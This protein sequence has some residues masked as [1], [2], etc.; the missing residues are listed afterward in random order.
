MK[1]NLSFKKLLPHLLV[2]VGFMV[3]SVAYV[4]P[5]LKGK[6][7]KQ[8]DVVQGAG[9]SHEAME[10]MKSTGEWT[11]W[12]N[13]LFGG[14]PTFMVQGGYA[15]GILVY[16]SQ[17]TNSFLWTYGGMIFFYLLGVYL[18]LMALE[19]GIW[20]SVL[21]AVAYAFFSYNIIIIE[22]G[23]N[24]K[25]IAL[26]F[27]PMMLAGLVYVFKKRIWLGAALFSLGTGL[28]F[29]SGHY[30]IAYYA[31][32]LIVIFGIFEFFNALKNKQLG[33]FLMGSAL[34]I[35]MAGLIL[36]SLT[37]RLWSANDYQKETIR[38]GSELTANKT[39]SGSG[40]DRDYAFEYSYGKLESLTLL[41]P[42]F[43]GGGA[44]ANLDEKS[45]AFK[46][47]S[48][49]GA[50]PEQSLQTVQG[51]PTYWGDQRFV[52]GA[53]YS[54][55]ILLF[56][57]CLGL[58]I[59][60]GRFKYPFVVGGVLCMMI[61]WGSNFSIL[62]NL[63]FDYLPM[64]NKFRSLSMIQ[65]LAQLC[66]VVVAGL[67][68][69]KIAENPSWNALKKPFF[70]SLG[71]TGGLCLVFTLIPSLLDMRSANDTALIDQLTEMFGK[72][73]VA[74][75]ELYNALVEDRASLLRSDAFRSLIFI[76]LAAGLLW[77]FITQKLKNA[78]LVIGI[79]S[80][81]VLIDLWAVAKRNLNDALFQPKY[82]SYDE[83]F[84]P[85][86]ATQ[87]ILQ[88][89]DPNFRVLDV[90][91]SPFNDASPSYFYKNVGGGH[92]AKLRR[93]QE[94][95]DG[96]MSKNN[97]AVFNMLNTKYFVVAGANNQPTP[98][99]NPDALGNAWFVPEVKIVANADEEMKSLDK[100]DPKQI[101][102][103]D[104]QFANQLPQLKMALDTTNKIRL[105]E[106][107]PNQVSY[108]SNAKSDQIA[109]FSEV[110]YRGGI[111]WKA[112]IDGVETPHFRANYVLRGMVVPKG[113]HTIVFKFDPRS[114]R[115]GTQID[116]YA[117]V[118]WVLLFVFAL[119]MD[120][121]RKKDTVL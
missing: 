85:S 33:T 12:T 46:V 62:N 1:P 13:A 112:Y 90:T 57:F 93:Y 116:T 84:Q 56:L 101:A 42:N 14:M 22:V 2:I 70:I 38:G 104:K 99:R 3:L 10:Y 72:N 105:T 48:R 94:L 88:D 68:L 5:V 76:L 16:I 47:L 27:V 44:I 79:L 53:V 118:A 82:Y 64:F 59:A 8:S 97:M 40:L 115:V 61:S 50:S 110:Y 41:I 108:T 66:F 91:I 24:S 30:Q 96:Q 7:L 120:S 73:K 106:Y 17:F 49:Y 11:G 89:K 15:K 58:L 37:S 67:G 121:R 32:L 114:V 102:F 119:F 29:N 23:H 9:S 75:N 111:D 81:L 52:A 63:L 18:L 78:S 20:A 117:S 45:A 25:A 36:A 43:S 65:A 31:G 60:D 34:T 103:V 69:K 95:I 107:K 6:T 55:A 80:F 26:G 39:K 98:Q 86:V 100:F 77:A 54:G 92:P 21:G 83:I 113:Q 87:Q 71:V 19:C 74:A 28:C 4:S 109:V 35:M 51:L